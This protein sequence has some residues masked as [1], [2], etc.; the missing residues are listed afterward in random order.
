[1]FN[2]EFIIKEAG[3]LIEPAFLLY[4]Y[5]CHPMFVGL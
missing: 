5:N 1:M 2:F 4:I 3:S